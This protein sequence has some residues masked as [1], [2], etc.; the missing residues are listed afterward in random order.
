MSRARTRLSLRRPG[1][2]L[3]HGTPEQYFATNTERLPNESSADRSRD[4]V[5]IRNIPL[6]TGTGWYVS[7][8]SL[9]FSAVSQDVLNRD[10]TR[11]D[12]SSFACELCTTRTVLFS[13]RDSRVSSTTLWLFSLNFFHS[14]EPSSRVLVLL[15][16]FNHSD[17]LNL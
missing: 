13:F 1:C 12:E 3:K 11:R 8:F 9:R 16:F 10:E 17:D 5:E 6:I 2:T 4:R 14:F 15:A 7:V